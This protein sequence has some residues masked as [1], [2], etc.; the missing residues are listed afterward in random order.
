[1]QQ[2]SFVDSLKLVSS[3]LKVDPAEALER[4]NLP[5][6][7]LNQKNK[8]IS[9][10][11]YFELWES[12]LYTEKERCSVFQ[13][14]MAMAHAPFASPAYAFSCSPN[15]LEGLKRFSVFKPLLGPIRFTV[16]ETQES[17]ALIIDSPTADAH[18]PD[19]MYWFELLYTM[20]SCRSL[21]TSHIVPLKV[22]MKELPPNRAAYEEYLGCTIT[23][24]S[25][26]RIEI[27]KQDSMLPLISENARLWTS[28]ERELQKE[29]IQN[30]SEQPV[31]VHVRSALM[32]LLPAGVSS[33]EAVSEQL[34][35]SRRSLQRK[36]QAEEKNYKQILE[37]TRR[38]LA[39]YYLS[40]P[41]ISVY[42][43]SFLLAFQEPNSFCRAFHNWAGMTPLEARNQILDERQ[44]AH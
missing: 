16:E 23:Q 37:S 1:M 4:S 12:T 30:D 20:E 33:V 3:I 2:Y 38:E 29:L 8:K 24:S 31:S 14:A 39:F 35:M 5:R 32:D 11:Q 28:F 27:S 40:K 26:L 7:Y 6:D 10:K 22:E 34:H 15:I 41:D 13:L 17:V 18:F 42:E 9:A 44:V 19:S 21:T 25:A 36:L 43:I